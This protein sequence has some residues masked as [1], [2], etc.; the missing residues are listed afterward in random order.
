[1][2][3]VFS[4]KKGETGAAMNQP[5]TVA[6]VVR[7]V[8]SALPMFV[9]LAEFES[10]SPDSYAA[11]AQGD[12]RQTYE[13]WLKELKKQAG[14]TWAPDCAKRAEGAASGGPSAPEPADESDD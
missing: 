14:L 12:M 2:R 3:E 5:Q 6:Y 9:L 8:D 7:T 4:L 11:L 13:S 10:S 1:M